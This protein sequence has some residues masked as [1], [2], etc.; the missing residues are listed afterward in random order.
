MLCVA[1]VGR[2]ASRRRARHLKAVR[3]QLKRH[4][5]TNADA[6]G[7]Q[8]LGDEQFEFGDQLFLRISL[9]G[10][11]WNIIAGGNSHGGLVVPLGVNGREWA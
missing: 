8:Q 4:V 5:R 7:L 6:I 3:K 1:L 9:G 10:K 2:Q 11:P